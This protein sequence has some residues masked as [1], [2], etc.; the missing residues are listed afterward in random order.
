MLK[1]RYDSLT[2]EASIPPWTFLK[3][4]VGVPLSGADLESS[5]GR[6]ANLRFGQNLPKNCMELQK[7]WAVGGAGGLG[8]DPPLPLMFL[9]I[10]NSAPHPLNAKRKFLLMKHS[11]VVFLRNDIYKMTFLFVNRSFQNPVSVRISAHIKWSSCYE[12]EAASFPIG[13]IIWVKAAS[14]NSIIISSLGGLFP[15]KVEAVFVCFATCWWNQLGVLQSQDNLVTQTPGILR[16]I[17]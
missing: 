7:F 15:L 1:Y 10:E 13:S 8:L 3:N 9:P 16:F 4:W 12:H 5:V 11:L 2:I 14:L 6:G 17:I